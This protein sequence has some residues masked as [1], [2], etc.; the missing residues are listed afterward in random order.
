M[1]LI[2]SLKKL[3]LKKLQPGKLLVKAAKAIG[4]PVGAAASLAEKAV[5][6]VKSTAKELGI[7]ETEA[8]RVV[9]AQGEQALDATA[10]EA[11]QAA[12]QVGTAVLAGLVLWLILGRKS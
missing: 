11:K 2:S 12:M 10:P 9:A 3:K 5:A 7:S 4:G 8:A 1:G 6:R